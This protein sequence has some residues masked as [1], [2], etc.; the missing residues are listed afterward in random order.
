MDIAVAGGGIA[1]LSAAPARG[2][3]P[4]PDAVKVLADRFDLSN[5]LK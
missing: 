5:T 4:E 1:G 2:A 3:A